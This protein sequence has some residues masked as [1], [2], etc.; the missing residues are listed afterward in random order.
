MNNPECDLEPGYKT[1][2]Y[3]ASKERK[4]SSLIGLGHSFLFTY[5]ILTVLYP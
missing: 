3:N 5:S 1:Q 2:G 4:E